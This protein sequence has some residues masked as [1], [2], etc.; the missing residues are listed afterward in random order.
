MNESDDFVTHVGI[1][2]R[3]CERFK[4]RS[5][6]DDQFKSLVFLCSL[7]SPRFSD[8]R[9]RL[10]NRLEQDPTLTLSA[11][12]DEYQRLINLQRDTTLVQSRGQD[13]S[14]VHVVQHQ[15]K[16][17]R[18]T[19]SGPSNASAVPA[20]NYSTPAQKKPPSPCWH[21]GAWHYVKFYPFQQHVCNHC[22]KVG[23]RNGFRQTAQFKSRRNSHTQRCF[24][25]KPIASSRSLVA[26]FH[27]H[28]A[29]RRK[30][31]TL[32]INGQPIRLQ[33]D[34]ASDI[35]ILLEKAW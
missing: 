2:N 1:V 27:N 21:C 6:T 13:G 11:I 35:T 3:E 25:K 8:I 5:L 19:T 16:S 17:S 15:I 9:T 22:Q 28:A 7:Q 20:A 31:L 33:L 12:T 32:S 26:V 4:L 30:Y 23:H 24:P 34:T 29:S 14:G 10:L 18:S